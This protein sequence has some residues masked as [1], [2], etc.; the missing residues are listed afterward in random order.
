MG[1]FCRTCD[2]VRTN[3]KFSGKGHRTQVCKDCSRHPN[4]ERSR[5][6]LEVEIAGFLQQS[7]ISRKNLT[8]LST[9]ATSQKPE[10]AELAEVVLEI[11]RIKPHGRRRLSFLARNHHE[12]INSLEETILIWA[13][14]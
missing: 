8:R 14:H 4:E 11:G 7:N 2:R 12:W 6:E 9:L 1:H 10:I 3:E 13:C 5:R